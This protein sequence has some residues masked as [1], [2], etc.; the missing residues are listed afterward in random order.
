VARVCLRRENGSHNCMAGK[1]FEESFSCQQ[2]L[3]FAADDNPIITS[4]DRNKITLA[5]FF[6]IHTMVVASRNPA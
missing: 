2:R 5:V 4:W 6:W 3:H 1:G